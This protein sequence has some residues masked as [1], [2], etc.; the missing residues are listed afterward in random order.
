VVTE[1]LGDAIVGRRPALA[2][3][4]LALEFR[5]WQPLHASGLSGAEAA[6]TMARALRCL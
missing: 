4:D 2:A 5:T 3:L 1:N 6:D